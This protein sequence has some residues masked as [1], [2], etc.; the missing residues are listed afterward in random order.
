MAEKIPFGKGL[1]TEDAP[2]GRLLGSRCKSCG[3]LYFPPAV[4]CY[5]CLKEEMETVPLN[6]KGKLVAYTISYMASIHFEPPYAVGWIELPEGVHVFA[7]LKGG[8]EDL[9]VGMDMELIIEKLW[10]EDGKEVIG[11][12]FQPLAS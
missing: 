6:R 12:K 2:G 5:E 4:L 3:Q 1:F 11:Y 8:E 9:K 7:P 10:D